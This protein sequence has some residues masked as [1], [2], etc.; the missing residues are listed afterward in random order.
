[1]NQVAGDVTR[2]NGGPPHQTMVLSK[3]TR[4]MTV[5]ISSMISTVRLIIRGRLSHRASAMSSRAA[6]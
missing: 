4:R 1:M 2:L 5:P 3:G 6:A